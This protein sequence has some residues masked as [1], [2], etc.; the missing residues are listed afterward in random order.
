MDISKV[1]IPT[2]GTHSHH[3]LPFTHVLPHALLPLNEKPALHYAAEESL[4]AQL[5][6]FFIVTQKTQP[7]ISSY[8]SMSNDTVS[9]LKELG[10]EHLL[11]EIERIIRIADFSY[12]PQEEFLGL[13]HALWLAR[14]AIHKEHFGILLPHDIV[15]S[16]QSAM[17]QIIRIA[18]QEKASVIAVQ[19]LP[20][21]CLSQYGVIGIK[22]QISHSL[23][24]VSHIAHKPDNKTTPSHCAIVGRYVLSHKLFN[25]LEE[26]TTY[27]VGEQLELHDAINNMIH[28]GEKVLA[29]KIQGIR[30]DISSP[31]G[32]IKA[33]IGLSLQ[34]PHHA[35]AIKRFI[36]DLE[37]TQS[38]FYNASKTIEHSL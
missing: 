31:I 33:V 32:W 15:V 17:D 4:A 35:P 22:K 14:H 8:F 1:I 19:E 2:V 36:K 18:R 26:M 34:S 13:G 16:K 3:F 10:K 5:R 24:H 30:Y 9:H 37:T 29:Y 27:S 23:F 28:N 20:S 21:E 12:I 7:A 38:F 25:A 6:H 11:E